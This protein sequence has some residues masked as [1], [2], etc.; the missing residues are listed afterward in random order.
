LRHRRAMTTSW[1]PHHLAALELA[2]RATI[3]MVHTPDRSRL[4]GGLVYWDMWPLQGPDGMPAKLAGRDMWMALSAP[5]RGDPAL[6]HFEAKIHWLERTGDARL[7]FPMSANG[8]A[9]PC[10]AMAR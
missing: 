6:R 8:Q 7:L 3:P 10:C 5:D 9:L 4:D 1:T 2:D